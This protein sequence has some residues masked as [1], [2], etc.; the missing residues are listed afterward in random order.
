MLQTRDLAKL[1]IVLHFKVIFLVLKFQNNVDAE[2]CLGS[3]GMNIAYKI[4]ISINKPGWWPL[5]H[6]LSPSE[7][8][9]TTYLG[10]KE[11]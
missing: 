3:L 11:T 7:S 4:L 8:D 2:S 10:T 6:N 9:G 5:G 1:K